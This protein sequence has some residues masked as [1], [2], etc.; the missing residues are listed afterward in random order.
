[1]HLREEDREQFAVGRLPSPALRDF[2]VH[3]LI[4]HWCQDAMADMDA[5]VAAM[6][7]ASQEAAPTEARTTG[8][9]E[10]RRAVFVWH[11]RAAASQQ[12]F[13]FTP[14]SLDIRFTLECY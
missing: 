5:F 13:R 2:E 7:A 4:C 12:D 9:V 1:M 3:L 6:R 11:R 10:L 14:K 8:P